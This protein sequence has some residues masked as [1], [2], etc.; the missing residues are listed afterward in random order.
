MKSEKPVKN[1]EDG[2]EVEVKFKIPGK[3][4]IKLIIKGKEA[5]DKEKVQGYIDAILSKT[6]Q[7]KKELRSD[8]VIYFDL[9]SLSIKEKLLWV[10]KNNFKYGWFRSTDV[11]EEYQRQFGETINPS[12]VSTYLARLYNKGF[13]DR[14]GDRANREYRVVEKALESEIL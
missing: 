1:V 8:E 11:K 6:K 3:G 4:E 10:I 5:L 13:L 9:N 14:R 2:A 12:T 7:E